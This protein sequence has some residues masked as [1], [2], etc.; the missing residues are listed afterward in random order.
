[1]AIGSQMGDGGLAGIKEGIIEL[2]HA[3]EGNTKLTDLDISGNHV[4]DFEALIVIYFVAQIWQC[5]RGGT[6]YR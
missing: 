4:R 2:A 3:M 1:M 5:R 6:V